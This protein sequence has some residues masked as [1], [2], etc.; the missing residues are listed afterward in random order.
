MYTA[1]L[2]K[3][4]LNLW[5]EVKTLKSKFLRFQFPLDYQQPKI[6]SQFPGPLHLQALQHADAT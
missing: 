6:V 5:T 3:G 1:S 2:R 4:T